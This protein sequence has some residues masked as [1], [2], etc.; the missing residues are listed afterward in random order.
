MKRMSRRAWLVLLV[1]L[2]NAAAAIVFFI[3]GNASAGA[4]LAGLALL[5]SVQFFRE[6]TTVKTAARKSF[7]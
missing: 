2:L 4:G 7:E 5:G 1:T 3:K 6:V